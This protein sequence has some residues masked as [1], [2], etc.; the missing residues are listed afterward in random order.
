MN[1]KKV[2]HIRKQLRAKGVE[3]T[4]VDYNKGTPPVY[5]RGHYEED[6]TF[7]AADNTN[8]DDDLDTFVKVSRGVPTTLL[9]GCGRAM[10][11]QVKG[12]VA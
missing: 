7:V 8:P 11:K 5:L 10:Y 6:S 9:A 3:P 1:Q 2:K 12:A 4:K